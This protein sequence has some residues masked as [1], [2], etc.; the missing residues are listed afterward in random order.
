MCINCAPLHTIKKGE[1]ITIAKRT[2]L[3]DVNLTCYIPHMNPLIPHFSHC[4]AI[5]EP[6]VAPVRLKTLLKYLTHILLIWDSLLI[7]ID[8]ILVVQKRIKRYER[9][10]IRWILHTLTFYI[11]KPWRDLIKYSHRLGLGNQLTVR[12]ISIVVAQ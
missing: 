11:K 2:L 10:Q 12:R 5:G 8:D 7:F 1:C 9:G 6:L 4:T 3:S